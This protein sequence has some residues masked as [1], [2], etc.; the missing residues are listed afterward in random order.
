MV[1]GLL[2]SLELSGHSPTMALL[3]VS[4]GVKIAS[5]ASQILLKSYLNRVGKDELIWKESKIAQK[6]IR[7]DF[8]IDMKRYHVRERER[9]ACEN[10]YRPSSITSSFISGYLHLSLFSALFKI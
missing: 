8:E 10:F 4:S 1:L 7:N 9:V 3:L 5:A 6:L 2:N